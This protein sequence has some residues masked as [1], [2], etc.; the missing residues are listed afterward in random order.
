MLPRKRILI[1]DDYLDVVTV[2]CK[3]LAQSGYECRGA[4]NG[5]DAVIMAWEF[6]PDAILMDLQMPFMDGFQ[7][8]RLIRNQHWSKEPVIVAFT[9]GGETFGPKLRSAGFDLVV[10]KPVEVTKLE[11]LLAEV[12]AAA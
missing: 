2:Y 8:C 5:E 11:H 10:T 12:L 6:H 9:S 1:V 4:I 3:L 7:A